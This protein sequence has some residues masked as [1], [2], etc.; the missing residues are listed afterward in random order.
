MFGSIR[1]KLTLLYT[2]LTALALGGFALLFYFGLTSVLMKEEERDVQVYAAALSHDAGEILRKM[3][4]RRNEP[5]R[6]KKPKTLPGETAYSYYLLSRDGQIVLENGNP[7]DA[8]DV[9]QSLAASERGETAGIQSFS[10]PEGKIVRILWLKTPVVEEGRRLGTLLVGKDLE[11]YD[12]FL[13]RLAQALGGSALLFLILSGFIGH[14]AAGRALVPI[15][16]S[17][18]AQRRFVADASHELRTPLSVIQASLD[19]VEKEEAG[20]MSEFSQQVVIDLKDEVRRMTRLTADL[21][22]L[23]RSDTGR[24]ELAKEKNALHSLGE[25]VCRTLQPLAQQRGITLAC[26]YDGPVSVDADK[27]RLA[28]LLWILLDNALK[29]TP[30][31]GKVTLTV[32]GG[33]QQTGTVLIAVADTGP[34]VAA[35]ERERIFERFYRTDQSRSR[36]AG[37][38][39]LGLS[40]ATAIVRAHGGSLALEE[41]PGGGSIFQVRL[42][43]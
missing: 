24:L 31:G 22:T 8:R 12:H 1:Q 40:I 13:R 26:L 42:P 28:Q 11:S 30:D 17:F 16:R 27:D 38:A 34:G 14:F 25:Q 43:V 15:R 9:F 7:P 18:E 41:N 39:G 6:E 35:A 5:E 37:G 2:V 19:V 20:R 3:E 36:E 32:T 29:F 4:R 33:K 10:L 21:L 23:A